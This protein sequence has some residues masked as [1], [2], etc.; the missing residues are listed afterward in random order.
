MSR[1]AEEDREKNEA[2]RDEHEGVANDEHRPMRPRSHFNTEGQ[3]RRRTSY[4]N[5]EAGQ[6]L[7]RTSFASGVSSARSEEFTVDLTESV[8][9]ALHTI[10]DNVRHPVHGDGA[11]WCPR[12]PSQADMHSMCRDND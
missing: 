6:R 1:I 7:R 3:Q 12:R 8:E 10:G 2:E 5:S 4:F 11:S 9:R